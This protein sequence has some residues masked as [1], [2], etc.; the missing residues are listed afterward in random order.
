MWQVTR[1]RKKCNIQAEQ[2]KRLVTEAEAHRE[3]FSTL[4]KELEELKQAATCEEPDGGARPQR[5]RADEVV[6]LCRV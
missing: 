2:I 1:L 4:N 6:W 3:E 5:S